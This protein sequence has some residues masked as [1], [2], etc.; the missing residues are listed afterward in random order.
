MPTP[1]YRIT[2]H[3]SLTTPI[4]LGGAPRRFAILNGTICAAF[5]LGLQLFYLLPVFIVIHIVAVILAKRDPY[6]FEVV[7]RHLRQKKYYEV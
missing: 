3:N 7:L 2:L 5:V 1:G 6:F 4:L